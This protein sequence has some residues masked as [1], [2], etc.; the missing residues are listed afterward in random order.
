VGF[1]HLINE[2]DFDIAAATI[3]DVGF[4]GLFPK[5]ILHIS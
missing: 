5:A 2:N 3:V 4:L 1:I